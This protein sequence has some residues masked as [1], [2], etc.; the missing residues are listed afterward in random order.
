MATKT[1]G[2]LPSDSSRGFYG[3]GFPTISPPP[4]HYA[5]N[6]SGRDVSGVAG[7]AGVSTNRIRF[8][9]V[10]PDVNFDLAISVYLILFY[11]LF[12]IDLF[13]KIKSGV[14]FIFFIF[15]KIPQV[16]LYWRG[17][18]ALIRIN[19]NGGCPT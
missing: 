2:M 10:K 8:V 5:V 11:N 19:L 1:D 4:I 16:C 7:G 12:V 9:S 13:S 14:F 3:C 17:F 15:F 18:L 6:H